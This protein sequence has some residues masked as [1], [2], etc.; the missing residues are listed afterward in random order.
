[1]NPSLKIF[2]KTYAEVRNAGL[3]NASNLDDEEKAYAN[4][5][6]TEGKSQDE[7]EIIILSRRDKPLRISDYLK[8]K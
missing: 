2:T 8:N 5:T 7:R 3:L 6:G 1:M 4:I